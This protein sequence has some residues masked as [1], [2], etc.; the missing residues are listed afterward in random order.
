MPATLGIRVEDKNRWER[1]APLIPRHVADLIARHG[2]PV[3]IES[4]ALRIFP[5]D[6]YRAAGAR[7][8]PSVRDC[9]L[10]IGVKEM[11]QSLFKPHGAYCY[12]SH[13]IKGQSENMP[14][15]KKLLELKCTLF[16]YEK[17]ADEQ[18]RRLIF[19]GN[20]AGKAG[21]LDTLWALGRRLCEEGIDSPFAALK[22]AHQY[23]DLDQAKAAVAVAGETIKRDGLPASISPLVVGVAG[24]GNV[25]RGAQEILRKL[26]VTELAPQE[27]PTLHQKSFSTKTIYQVIFK[28][29]DLVRPLY[30]GAPFDLQDYYKN[31]HKYGSKFN[32]YLPYLTVLENCIFW[33]QRYPRLVTKADLRSM[34]ASKGQPR[35]R[36]IGDISCDKEGA[37]EA[38]LRNTTPDDPVFVYLPAKDEIVGGVAG[39]GPVVLA[40]DNLPCELP[41]ESSEFFSEMLSKFIPDLLA[42]D[43]SL[44]FSELRLPAELK[45]A[46]V[47]HQGKLAPSFQ[48]LEKHLPPG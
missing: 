21:M 39:N 33:D 18:G 41:R 11:P 14:A 7:I 25:S 24:Y 43:Y 6:E 29:E 26:P 45:K 5:D 28:E 44:P 20:F 38:T 30:N 35:L 2:F 47:A 17:A 31:P 23:G 13:T 4:S 36:V 3:F 46:V 34:F 10:I 15:L 37:I 9:D 8:V 32:G 40:V 42:A 12:F 22:P 27:L 16:D 48:Y 19:F 1:R